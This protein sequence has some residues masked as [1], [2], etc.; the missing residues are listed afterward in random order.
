MKIFPKTIILLIFLTLVIPVLVFA[1]SPGIPH[2]FYG[3]VS[4]DNGAATDGLIVEAK[5]GNTVFGTSIT[6]GGKYGYGDLLLVTNPDNNNAGETV[7]FYVSGIKANEPAIFANNDDTIRSTPL[8]LTVPGIVGTIEEDENTV[9]ED[10]IIAIAPTQPTNIKLGNN[11]NINVTSGTSTNAVVN[12]V[13]KLTDSFFEG[14]TAVIA[15]NNLLN[16]FEINITG[17]NL[18]IS[19]TITYD[20]TGIDEDTIKPYRFDGDSWVAF[21][22]EDYNVNTSANTITFSVSSAETP[23]AIFGSEPAP[24]P[25]PPASSG[26][27]GGTTPPVTYKTGD[28]DQNNKVDIFDFNTL[29]VNWGNSPANS[30]ADLDNNG[31]VDI[32]DFN[33]LMVNWG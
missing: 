20:D 28:T 17:D 19:V 16:A 31:K 11:L 5:I 22:S 13:K 21:N 6:E 32:F 30:A 29:M 9:I 24:E 23:Y 8:N 4:F 3:T 10:K 15:G 27:G 2:K 18:T 12:E 25:T 7:E 33:L 14:S 26:G 1:Q